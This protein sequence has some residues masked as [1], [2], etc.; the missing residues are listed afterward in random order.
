[1]LEW[2]TTLEWTYVA[3]GLYGN[4]VYTTQD[5]HKGFEWLMIIDKDP[6]SENKTENQYVW[7]PNMGT[8]NY[9]HPNLPNMKLIRGKDGNIFG[10]ILVP[11]KEDEELF[12]DH[13]DLITVLKINNPKGAWTI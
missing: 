11:V 8:I 1:M 6:K 7:L 5:L 4:G 3:P 13:I 2:Q 9:S 10:H 12:Y